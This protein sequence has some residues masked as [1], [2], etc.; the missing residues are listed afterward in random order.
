MC[1]TFHREIDPGLEEAVVSIIWAVP[2]MKGDVNE[3]QVVEDMF[4]KRYS[5]EFI[6]HCHENIHNKVNKDLIHKVTA[7]VPSKV[8]F[9]CRV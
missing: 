2:R 9:N 7:Y 5:K 8:S 1:F 6:Q 3:L 4:T